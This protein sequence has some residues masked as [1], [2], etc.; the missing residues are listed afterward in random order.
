M[1][2]GKLASNE[3]KQQYGTLISKE[4]SIKASFKMK[5]LTPLL[6]TKIQIFEDAKKELMKKFGDKDESGELIMIPIEETEEKRLSL[7]PENE[8]ALNKEYQELCELDIDVPS[9]SA[10]DF[11]E[12]FK[13]SPLALDLLEFITE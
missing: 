10:S 6:E 3:F 8:Q 1:K 4:M 13:L 12:D 9:I 7:T 5:E 2:L 11:G